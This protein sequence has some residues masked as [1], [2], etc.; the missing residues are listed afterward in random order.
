[1][2]LV[3]RK[4]CGMANTWTIIRCI[5]PSHAA[6]FDHREQAYCVPLEKQEVGRGNGCS[7]VTP[8]TPFCPSQTVVRKSTLIAQDL[9]GEVRRLWRK[10][11]SHRL[12]G[13]RLSMLGEDFLVRLL[14]DPH[15]AASNPSPCSVKTP[16]DHTGSPRVSFGGT[17]L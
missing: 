12:R 5:F 8:A 1:M 14:R 7:F 4:K 10:E 3:H 16:G 9:R 11:L 17:L 15:T 2:E 6:C 13:K